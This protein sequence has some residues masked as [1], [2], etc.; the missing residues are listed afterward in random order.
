MP[1]AVIYWQ[2]I[3]NLRGPEGLAG[4]SVIGPQG[5]QGERGY[6][7]ERGE[8]GP[9]GAQGEKG[10]KGL[11]G[12]AGLRGEPGLPG[13]A[14]EPGPQGQAGDPG[15][16]GEPGEPGPRGEPGPAGE[17]GEQGPQ[18]PVG[19]SGERG[20][21]G[22]AGA[23]GL[24]GPRGE[25]GE[26]GP[27]GERGLEGPPGKLP[28]VKAYEPG[29]VA[30]QGDV[31]VHQGS[32]WQAT[33]DTAQA[34]PHHDWIGLAFRGIDGTHGS[35]PEPRGLWKAE[36]D[37]HRLD[38]VTLNGS[39]FLARKDAPGACPGPD[40]QLLVSQGKRG[41]AGESITGPRGERGEKGERGL[42]GEPAPRLLSWQVDRTNYRAIAKMSDGSEVPLELRGLF[43]QFQREI[44][45]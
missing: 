21:P 41:E 34:P 15:E 7:G 44:D 43:Q 32:S 14:G 18:G 17:R 40:W 37:Y 26:V 13:A 22:D 4:E 23:P 45:E 42:E 24:A 39:S 33:K 27:R 12:I 20:A 28:I 2:K 6:P 16:P 35:S 38:I 30:Y 31:V 1:D 11:P 19:P 36:G 9:Q 5:L 3:G 8:H 10:E 29:Q 25:T